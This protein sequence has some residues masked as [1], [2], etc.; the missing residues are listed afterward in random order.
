MVVVVVIGVVGS[1]QSKFKWVGEGGH[2]LVLKPTSLG[3]TKAC[4]T[5]KGVRGGWWYLCNQA[6]M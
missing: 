1:K 2:L 3:V 4:M 6:V 5:C